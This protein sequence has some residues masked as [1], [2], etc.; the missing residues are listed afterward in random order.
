VF[1]GLG[2]SDEEAQHYEREF[3]AGRPIVAVRADH[4]R[5]D[6]TEILERHGGFDPATRPADPSVRDPRAE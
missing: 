4:R 1:N 5:A 6:A 3:R 2:L